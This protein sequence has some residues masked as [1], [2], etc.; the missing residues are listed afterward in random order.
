MKNYNITMKLK[1]YH[2]S[3]LL[4][5]LI[6]F[7]TSLI[8]EI[9]TIIYVSKIDKNNM[10]DG[11]MY[12]LCFAL[13]LI[14][15]IL[16]IVNTIISFKKG[17]SYI[18][19][20]AYNENKSINRNFLSVLGGI[21][22]FSIFAIIYFTLLYNGLKLPLS[23]MNQNIC[24]LIICTAILLLINCIY[25]ILFPIFATKDISIQNIETTKKL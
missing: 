16:E 24:S 5:L 11:I 14:F 23:G 22:I 8:F 9:I 18:V 1:I 4:F 15:T 7:T 3:L 2:I 13:L 17:S 12:I 10:M 21:S 25:T 20:L 6:S 19:Y